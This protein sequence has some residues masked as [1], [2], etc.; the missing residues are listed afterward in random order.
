M[1]FNSYQFLFLFL[2]ITLLVYF[3]AARSG[4]EIAILWLVLASLFFYGWWN[5]IYLLLL[6]ASMLVNFGIGN[7]LSLAHRERRHRIGRLWLVVGIGANLGVLG[8]YKYANFAVGSLNAVAGT[9]FHLEA[10]VL[11]LAISFF[12]FQQVAYLV[13]AYNGITRE[14][15]FAHYALFVTFFPQLIAGPIVHHKDM[16]PQFMRDEGLRPQVRNIAVGLTIFVIGLF[17]KV[18]LADGVAQYG[19]PVF[20]AAAAGA[21]LSLLE[22]WG[23]ALAYT[24]QLY[25]DFS[26]YSDMAIGAAR[27]FGIKLPVNFHSPYKATNIVEFW[28]RWHITL[29]TFLRDYLYVALGGNRAGKVMRYRNLLLTMLLGGLWHG[30][31]WTFVLW[32]ALHGLYLCINHA[33]HHLIS[34]LQPRRLLPRALSKAL[35][36]G[37]TFTAVVVGWVFFRAS[38]FDA[39]DAILRG[40]A[41]INGI[42]LPAGMAVE[43]GANWRLLAQWGFTTYPDS[44]GRFVHTWLW[45]T[46][47]L[48]IALAMPNTQQVLRAADPG[49]HLP[50]TSEHTELR[51]LGVLADRICWA[52]TAAW[53]IFTGLI[54]TICVL[55]LTRLSEFLYFQF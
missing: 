35:A 2:P 38:S 7:L 42:A 21:S 40:M 14:Y 44:E 15:R 24:L 51:P 41:G 52:P 54:A 6:V 26:G 37:L 48:P 10:I 16:L 46:C 55:S 19:T 39:A 20:N 29:S 11:P 3:R 30:A 22:A 23:G 8:Y 34:R 17:K 43:L 13:D 12:T 27:L 5:P 4:R 25:F 28:R 31:G 53:A 9:H 45:I 18:V 36:W 33:W 49:L 50:P 32:G 47:L 1:L